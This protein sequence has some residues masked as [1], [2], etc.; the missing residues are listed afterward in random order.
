VATRAL[1]TVPVRVKAGD[2]FEL[3][4]LLQ[5]AM[6]SGHRVDAQG[7]RLPRSIVR[8]FEARFDGQLVCAVDLHAAIAAN[9]YLAVWLRIES[10]GEL[11]LRWQGDDA[12]EHHERRR[13]DLI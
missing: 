8:R 3:R 9:P 13:I 10:P 5:H 7:Q 2:A 1:V 4:A 11:H 12:F 6:E